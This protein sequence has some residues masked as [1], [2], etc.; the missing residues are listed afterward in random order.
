MAS[1]S[2]LCNL[3][4]YGAQP[5]KQIQVQRSH[6]Q[7]LQ[8]MP[9]GSVRETCCRPIPSRSIAL[10]LVGHHK[11]Q[12]QV[13]DGAGKEIKL[14]M[15]HHHNTMSSEVESSYIQIL[16]VIPSRSLQVLGIR[17]GQVSYTDILG[18]QER[19]TMRFRQA[20]RL[21]ILQRIL[22]TNSEIDRTTLPSCVAYLLSSAWSE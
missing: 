18:V 22:G 5:D 16:G 3:V 6:G 17:T 2:V 11:S 1:G 7:S 21:G 4:G 19:E 10:L 20:F 12:S 15:H 14:M 8:V 9:K 13:H